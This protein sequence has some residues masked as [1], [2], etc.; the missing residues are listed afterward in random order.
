M[1]VPPV[2]DVT[3]NTT[4]V[5]ML[6]AEERAERTPTVKLST[7]EPSALVL[8]TS[9]EIPTQDATPSALVT[10]TALVTRRVSSSSVAIPA[11]NPTPMSVDLEQHVK[12]PITKL[13]VLAPRDTPVIHS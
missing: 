2:R 7:T 13:S 10:M 6:A 4:G 5:R 1:S 11:M 9:W 8:L 3:D 12:P